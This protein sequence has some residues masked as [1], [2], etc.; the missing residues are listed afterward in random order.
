ME[1]G[2]ALALQN[3]SHFVEISAAENVERVH[4]TLMAFFREVRTLKSQRTAIRQRR[5]SSSLMHVSKLISSLIGRGNNN[6]HSC[7]GAEI[8]GDK[9]VRHTNVHSLEEDR[10][11]G[12]SSDDVKKDSATTSEHK[13][14][15]TSKTLRK[16][17]SFSL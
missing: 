8:E 16:R 17:P 4:L 3:S 11:G 2:Q 7:G 1:D 13:E 10:S 14:F 6:S 12:K 9:K 15:K 5:P